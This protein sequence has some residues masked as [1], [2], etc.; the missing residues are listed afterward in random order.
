MRLETI[1]MVNK[2][3]NTTKESRTK[4]FYSGVFLNAFCEPKENL[5]QY[6]GRVCKLGI[7]SFKY[8]LQ[9]AEVFLQAFRYCDVMVL[10]FLL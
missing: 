6:V 5:T 10:D 4:G 8:M 3:S 9:L 1:S 7:I 2:I